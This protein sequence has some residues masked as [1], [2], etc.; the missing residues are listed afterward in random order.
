M[1][2]TVRDIVMDADL[3]RRAYPRWPYPEP[4]QPETCPAPEAEGD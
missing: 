2:L 3:W 1:P 4:E